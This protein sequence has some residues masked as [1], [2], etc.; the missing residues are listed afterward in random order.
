MLWH[1]SFL[2]FQFVLKYHWSEIIVFSEQVKVTL[3]GPLAQKQSLGE[4]SIIRLPEVSF[5]PTNSLFVVSKFVFLPLTPSLFSTQWSILIPSDHV[6]LL[7]K[8]S[9]G[10]PISL[11]MKAK[12]HMCA[13]Q[14]PAVKTLPNALWIHITWSPAFQSE[15][16]AYFSSSQNPTVNK[17]HVF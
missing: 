13:F 2:H 8:T 17:W 15:L 4:Q 11:G 14:V 1:N 10:Q 3:S 9:K 12:R 16:V 7:P 6:T 5:H